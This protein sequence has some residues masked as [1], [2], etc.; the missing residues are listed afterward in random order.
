MPILKDIR[1]TETIELP[2]F[3][4]SKVTL[5]K[6]LLF[7]QMRELEKATSDM[8]RGLLAVKLMIKEWNFTDENDQV[9]EINEASLNQL[10]MK[11]LTLLLEK[12]TSFLTLAEKKTKKSSKGSS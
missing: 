8:E 7:G 3:P 1:K 2:S 11:D 12:V 10:P 6:G 5:F 9:K 4:G